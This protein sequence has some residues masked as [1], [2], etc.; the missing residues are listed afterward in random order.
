MTTIRRLTLLLLLVLFLSN[1]SVESMAETH[2]EAE[3]RVHGEPGH[4]N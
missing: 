4:N 2:A 3:S 1:S